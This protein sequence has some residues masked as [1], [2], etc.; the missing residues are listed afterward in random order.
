MTSGQ[1]GAP[2]VPGCLLRLGLFAPVAEGDRLAPVP[3]SV[4]SSRA[5]QPYRQEII[6]TSRLLEELTS[7]FDAIERVYSDATESRLPGFTLLRGADVIHGAIDTAVTRCAKELMTAQPGG[8]RPA[9]ILESSLQRNTEIIE[10][11]VRQRTLYQHSVRAHQPTFE[12]ICKIV[13]AGGEVRTLD[14]MFDRLII[15]DRTVAFI[16]TSSA[17]EQEALEVREPAVV[18][19]LSNIFDN[20]WSRGIPATLARERRPKLVASDLERALARMLVAGYTEEK[21]ARDLG[22]SRRTIADHTSRLSRRLGST[23]RA[24]LGYLIASRGLLEDTVEDV[25]AVG[26]SQLIG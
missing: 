6:A 10:R 26:A 5:L 21:I 12:Y 23:S 24:Q 11:G 22:M 7:V 19:F 18:R 25:E 2:D 15:C 17:Y 3:A 1:V 9:E 16:P 8:G 13:A 4:A 14:E 20:A